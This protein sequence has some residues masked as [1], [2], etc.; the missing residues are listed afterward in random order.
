MAVA[1]QDPLAEQRCRRI[2]E[3][4]GILEILLCGMG[5]VNDRFA[6]FF[7]FVQETIGLS[8]VG[9]D[10]HQIKIVP[11]IRRKIDSFQCERLFLVLDR[12]AQTGFPD[13]FHTF[14]VQQYFHDS[15]LPSSDFGLSPHEEIN[16]QKHQQIIK[17]QRH[18]KE[19]FDEITIKPFWLMPLFPPVEIQ[20]LQQPRNA[21]CQE[22][23][24]QKRIG[25]TVDAQDMDANQQKRQHDIRHRQLDDLFVPEIWPE[26][27]IDQNHF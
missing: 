3:D 21:G 6:Q 10:V 23:V 19:Y 11:E 22:E 24:R 26:K 25:Q 13:V 16:A 17:N 15:G 12:S 5:V 7:D 14:G 2:G 8:E 18:Q 4:E 1:V 27:F 9:V 20:R